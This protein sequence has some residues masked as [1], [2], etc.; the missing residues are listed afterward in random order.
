VIDSK[1]MAM[2]SDTAMKL[3]KQ[4]RA[5]ANAFEAAD[6]FDPYVAHLGVYGN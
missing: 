4:A 6:F 3:G 2:H 5:A 1:I